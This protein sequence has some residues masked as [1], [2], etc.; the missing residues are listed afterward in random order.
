MA[1]GEARGDGDGSCGCAVGGAGV[2][3]AG[4]GGVGGAGVGGV[5][6]AGVGD[7][8]DACEPGDGTDD[9]ENRSTAAAGGGM[10]AGDGSTSAVIEL[11]VA[12]RSRSAAT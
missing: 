10:A 3:G 8:A 9:G 6:G 12:S 1:A 2:G 11:A 4:V 5:G 7:G